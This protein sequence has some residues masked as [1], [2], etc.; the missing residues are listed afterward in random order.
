MRRVSRLCSSQ[1]PWSGSRRY[2]PVGFGERVGFD[3]R[4]CMAS[5]I[6]GFSPAGFGTK[7]R[8]PGLPYEHSN[9][10]IHETR[11]RTGSAMKIGNRSGWRTH[12][13]ETRN[14]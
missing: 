10:L 3:A 4:L 7:H 11:L 14:I 13:R 6:P 9:T 12:E 1:S 2:W 5:A 8:Q